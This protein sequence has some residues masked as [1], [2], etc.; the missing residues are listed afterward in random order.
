M[1]PA[2]FWPLVREVCDPEEHARDRAR[3]V[4]HELI[5][6]R[7]DAGQNRRAALRR[8]RVDEHDRAA[9][10]QFGK[11]RP[12]RRIPGILVVVA[13]QDA[14]AVGL[15]HVERID[16]FGE[17][18]LHVGERHC[19]EISEA[20]GEIAQQRSGVLVARAGKFSR[21][22][23]GAAEHR[24]AGGRHREHC[25]CN[26]R[27]V[28]LLDRVR[29]VPVQY[30][31]G[32]GIGSGRDLRPPGGQVRWRNEMVVHVDAAGRRA[33][34]HARV[35]RCRSGGEQRRPGHGERSTVHAA[36]TSRASVL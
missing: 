16:G 15:Q 13:R 27:T 20:S 24:E 31:R 8:R 1:P 12:E 30:R 32:I 7:R 21:R 14:D 17:R 35:G 10:V 34:R 3:Y 6:R 5:E 36:A 9:P 18:S 4:E 28:H 19:R 22:V 33:L 23:A 26:S 29:G 2:N 11:E 25:N